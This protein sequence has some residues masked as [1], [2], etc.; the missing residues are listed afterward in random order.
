[1]W[2]QIPVVPLSFSDLSQN[3]LAG[4]I[5]DQYTAT[6]Y[7]R[8]GSLILSP[9]HGPGLCGPIPEGLRLGSENGG[10]IHSMMPA[11]PCPGTIRPDQQAHF[12]CTNMFRIFVRMEHG[13]L[14]VLDICTCS[15]K[16]GLLIAGACIVCIQSL[17]RQLSCCFLSVCSF[18]TYSIQGCHLCLW[19]LQ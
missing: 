3:Y 18:V 7:D 19:T 14:F 17:C 4:S 2:A 8:K 16:V 6:Q 11:G 15:Q 10:I 5:P 13:R 1:M 12:L 9:M